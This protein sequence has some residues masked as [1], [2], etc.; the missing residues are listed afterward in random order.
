MAK[1]FYCLFISQIELQPDVLVSLKSYKELRKKSNN[2]GNNKYT[3]PNKII[4]T[5]LRRQQNTRNTVIYLPLD[6]P[7]LS[8]SQQYF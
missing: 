2:I 3:N 4:K 5:S 1:I 8:D 7:N 6:V